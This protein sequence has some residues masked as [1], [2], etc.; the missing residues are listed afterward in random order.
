[1]KRL[2]K[3]TFAITMISMSGCASGLMSSCDTGCASAS[4]GFFQ[5]D[6]YANSI[7]ADGPVRRYLRGDQCSTCNA[8][9]GQTIGCDSNTIGTCTNCGVGVPA[10]DAYS[11]GGSYPYPAVQ[12][13]SF[14]VEGGPVSSF[15]PDYNS[16]D[17]GPAVVEP[18]FGFDGGATGPM[19]DPYSSTPLETV[20]PPF[21]GNVNFN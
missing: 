17:V 4:P 18:G 20:Q 6:W 21:N 16:G 5:S 14:P 1:M 12:N 9:A 7:F 8:P 13:G 15:Y 19:I 3:F 11:T 10:G 2:I